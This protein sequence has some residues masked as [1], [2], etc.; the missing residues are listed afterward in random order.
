MLPL[1]LMKRCTW[2]SSTKPIFGKYTFV[3]ASIFVNGSFI[4]NYLIELFGGPRFQQH[5]HGVDLRVLREAAMREYFRQPVVDTF[6]M[7]ITM[8]KSV[9]HIVDF[10]TA[11]E[12]D[13]HLIGTC[14]FFFPCILS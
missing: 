7:R 14:F 5:F 1:L 9:S 6:D 13:L 2:N 3:T 8:A 4:S 11:N 12:E 10:S